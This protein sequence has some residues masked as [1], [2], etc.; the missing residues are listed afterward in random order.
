MFNH[1][2]G[3]AKVS[4]SGE[5]SCFTKKFD[6]APEESSPSGDEERFYYDA[7]IIENSM[8]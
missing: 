8:F 4:V 5:R 7:N 6:Q 1:S 2:L 3:G